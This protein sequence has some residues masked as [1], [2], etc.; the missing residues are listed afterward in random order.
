MSRI[1]YNNTRYKHSEAILFFNRLI[2]D[3]KKARGKGLPRAYLAT[4]NI[5]EERLN[6]ATRQLADLEKCK[7]VVRFT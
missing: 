7:E 6:E 3:L 1:A 5:T 4:H 2:I